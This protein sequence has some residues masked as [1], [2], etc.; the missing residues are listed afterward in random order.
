MHVPERV[1]TKDDF[2]RELTG[3]LPDIVISDYSM[4]R[5]DGLMTALRLSNSARPTIPVIMLTGSMNE[6]TA[7]ACMKA[8]RATD[9]VIKEHT[10]R[11]GRRSRRDGEENR[12][13]RKRPCASAGHDGAARQA[14]CSLNGTVHIHLDD[15]RKTRDPYTADGG[16]SNAPHCG[17]PDRPR[18]GVLSGRG[19]GRPDRGGSPRPRQR[20]AIPSET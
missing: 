7:V 16:T 6:D 3:F 18:D 10:K 9:Y 20:F 17:R 5:F 1:E 4:P 12:S 14:A 8:G 2:L 15:R 11:L 19:G 13:G